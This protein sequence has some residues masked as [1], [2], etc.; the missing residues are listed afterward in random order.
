MVKRIEFGHPG[1]KHGGEALASRDGRGDGVVDTAY[2]KQS[3]QA[4]QCAGQHHRTDDDLFYF[5]AHILR[6]ILTFSHHSNFIAVFAVIQVN[7]HKYGDD[8]SH[9]I[10]RSA[11]IWNRTAVA[12][13]PRWY[14]G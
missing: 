9:A 5:D 6:G 12:A 13:S 11:D 1:Y 7:I 14:S 10:N 3:Y 4:A 8:D 2:Q